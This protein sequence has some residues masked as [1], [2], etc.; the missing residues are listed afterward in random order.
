MTA[1]PTQ[2]EASRLPPE[3]DA[4]TW[5]AVL[6]MLERITTTVLLLTILALVGAIVAAELSAGADA[7]IKSMIHVDIREA[8]ANFWSWL[9]T[10][11]HRYQ[12]HK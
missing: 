2:A 4:G 12:N 7:A 10:L 5:N 6:V 9:Q 11:W 8:L 1:Q 3:S